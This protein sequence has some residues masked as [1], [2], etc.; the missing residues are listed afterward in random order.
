MKHLLSLSNKNLSVK[1][2]IFTYRLTRACWIVE[3]SFSLLTNK[4]WMFYRPLGTSVEFSDNTLYDCPL[5]KIAVIGTRGHIQGVPVR[6]YF[7]SYFTQRMCSI[8]I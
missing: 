4:W 7:A 3:C 5:E 2:H 1:Q 8:S 6:D